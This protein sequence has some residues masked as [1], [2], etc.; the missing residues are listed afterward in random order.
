MLEILG[1]LLEA[2]SLAPA[3][4]WSCLVY[5]AGGTAHMGRKINPARF[6]YVRAR[7]LF[8]SF[9]DP[10]HCKPMLREKHDTCRHKDT[11][12]HTHQAQVVVATPNICRDRHLQRPNLCPADSQLISRR[13]ESSQLPWS[14]TAFVLNKCNFRARVAHCAFS[15]HMFHSLVEWNSD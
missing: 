8:F 7:P 6:L 10:K 14:C 11:H 1:H 13:A 4:W 2:R 3:V 15:A 5:L 9:A 12:T